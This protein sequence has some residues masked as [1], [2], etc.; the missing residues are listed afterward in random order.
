MFPLAIYDREGALYH[1]NYTL[2]SIRPP[3]YHGYEYGSRKLW[4]ALMA[5]PAQCCLT[6]FTAGLLRVTTYNST[7]TPGRTG[8]FL[9]EGDL[10]IIRQLIGSNVGNV[11]YP[12]GVRISASHYAPHWRSYVLLCP[13]RPLFPPGYFGLGARN[14]LSRTTLCH[15][16]H[17]G[18][19]QKF[20]KAHYALFFPADGV[21]QMP[22]LFSTDGGYVSLE[23][24]PPH[25]PWGV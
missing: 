25:H 17:I 16:C 2:F 8:P 15:P 14:F 12:P 9:V 24:R 13:P 22:S 1:I 18:L 10:M 5:R 23:T 7:T 19:C 20:F 21:P 6:S 3:I 4:S 11:H